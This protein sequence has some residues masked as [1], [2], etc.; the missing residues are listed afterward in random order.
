MSRSSSSNSTATAPIRRR[1]GTVRR[2][3]GISI[4]E[5]DTR[6]D[7]LELNALVDRGM[8]SADIARYMGK[9]PAWVSR[10]I[11][12]VR[13]NPEIAYRK[14]QEAEIVA[15]HHEQLEMLYTMAL[16]SALLEPE[17]PNL[18]AIRIA[19]HLRRQILDFEIRVGMVETRQRSNLL[20]MDADQLEMIHNAQ[21]NRDS[22]ELPTGDCE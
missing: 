9:D 11:R 22:D 14:P 8:R 18:Y 2:R 6:R 10:S 16:R 19:A 21:I 20:Q 5:A 13:D 3:L 12:R 7:L 4:R 15:G 17:K 1:G